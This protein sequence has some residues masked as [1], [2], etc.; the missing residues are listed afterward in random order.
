MT[1]RTR[2]SEAQS[3]LFDV[4]LLDLFAEVEAILRGGR[5]L[6]R[7][8][9]RVRD[10]APTNRTERRAAARRIQKRVGQLRKECLSLCGVASGLANAADELRASIQPA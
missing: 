8:A 5:E 6:Q 10:I 4:R 3:Q 9:L 7:D 1:K 2:S